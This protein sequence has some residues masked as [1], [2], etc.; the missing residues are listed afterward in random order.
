MFAGKRALQTA[1]SEINTVDYPC[2]IYKSL[3]EAISEQG[4]LPALILQFGSFGSTPYSEDGLVR[5][6]DTGFL[7]ITAVE[8]TPEDS[9][10]YEDAS[11]ALW[12]KAMQKI[13]GVFPQ[14]SIFG[15][16]IGPGQFGAGKAF[17]MMYQV[18]RDP[19]I[20]KY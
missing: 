8:F 20:K 17:V 13:L 4:P 19:N 15:Q 1:F 16:E 6:E 2:A 3:D 12:E 11:E 14:S 10:G 5:T 18:Q 7:V 9:N